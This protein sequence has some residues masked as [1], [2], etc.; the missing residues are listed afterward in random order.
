MA[1]DRYTFTLACKVCKN[2]NYHFA[3][4]KKKADRKKL[5]LK[6]FCKAC[7]KKTEH[8]ETKV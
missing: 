1:S 2:K 8:K 5:E 6:K 7:G 4:G 3:L